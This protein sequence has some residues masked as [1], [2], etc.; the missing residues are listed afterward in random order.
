MKLAEIVGVNPAEANEYLGRLIEATKNGRSAL[1]SLGPVPREV[2]VLLA[3]LTDD[4]LAARAHELDSLERRGLP[5][6]SVA[7]NEARAVLYDRRRTKEREAEIK[8]QIAK[9]RGGV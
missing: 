4:D 9:A 2:A 3:K 5:G 1:G 6:F 8:A 7:A